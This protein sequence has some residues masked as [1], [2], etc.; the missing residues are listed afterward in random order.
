MIAEKAMRESESHCFGNAWK[1]MTELQNDMIPKRR[2][3]VR[4]LPSISSISRRYRSILA[5][6]VASTKERMTTAH[7]ARP[8]LNVPISA[9]PDSSPCWFC[10]RRE[11][12]GSCET[13]EKGWE[14]GKMSGVAFQML[15]SVFWR[16]RVDCVEELRSSA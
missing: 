6:G 14:I 16:L 5:R 7:S 1:W 8:Q 15:P 12:G 3:D 13:S 10:A 9:K 11:G 4:S 2:A